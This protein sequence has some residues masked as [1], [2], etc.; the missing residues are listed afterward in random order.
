MKRLTLISVLIVSILSLS[1][2][3]AT[4]RNIYYTAGDSNTNVHFMV[5]K[6]GVYT[7]K[8]VLTAQGGITLNGTNGTPVY[9]SNQ[10][11]TS[12]DFPNTTTLYGWNAPTT[13][14][15]NWTASYGG[16]QLNRNGVT[17]LAADHLG[18]SRA[19]VFNGTTNY[20]STSNAALKLGNGTWSMSAWVYQA[21][22]AAASSG[23]IMGSATQTS[24][25]EGAFLYMAATYVALYT[26]NSTT[27]VITTYVDITGLS[28]GW[29][30][31]AVV[32]NS[33]SSHSMYVD[34]LLLSSTLTTGT[35]DTATA[36]NFD[37]GTWGSDT[38]PTTPITANIQSPWVHVGTAWTSEQVKKIYARGS[39]ILATTKPDGNID[40]QLPLEGKWFRYTPTISFTLGL[41]YSKYMVIKDTV[42]L[43]VAFEYTGSSGIVTLDVSLPI[44]A[45]N[46]T[47]SSFG[48]FAVAVRGAT[49]NAGSAYIDSSNVIRLRSD[50]LGFWNAFT[51][52]SAKGTY[53]W[54]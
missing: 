20:L 26:Y 12:A 15:T 10:Y 5:K 45:T 36:R 29:H 28:A 2:F 40:M 47:V 3:A 37:I 8:L 30:H 42:F 19:D 9:E 43:D 53:P 35:I 46:D 44:T 14:N 25:V 48:S 16:I 4:D 22:W 31:F 50:H 23:A 13:A 24:G 18:N 34:G 27:S 1:C 54:Q 32:R 38:T 39:R 49:Q 33:A 6:N 11:N 17:T 7:D 21:N 41:N 52:A 51:G